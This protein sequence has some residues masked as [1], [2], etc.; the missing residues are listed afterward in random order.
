MSEGNVTGK[1]T[2]SGSVVVSCTRSAAGTKIRNMKILYS[3]KI[4]RGLLIW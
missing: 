1:K 4:W 2:F 3:E